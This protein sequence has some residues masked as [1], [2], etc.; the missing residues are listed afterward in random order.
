MKTQLQ[1]L[2]LVLGL[3]LGMAGMVKADTIPLYFVGL[4]TTKVIKWDS[5][6]Q[7]YYI[8]INSMLNPTLEFQ[9]TVYI[10]Y[11]DSQKTKVLY[12]S[13]FL[14]A[15]SYEHI[16]PYT[17]NGNN[18]KLSGVISEN[19]G[20][21]TWWAKVDIKPIPD[22]PNPGVLEIIVIRP[23][24]SKVFKL[25]Q[26]LGSLP[27]GIEGI[28]PKTINENVF[29]YDLTGQQV[30]AG[31][32][33]SFFGQHMQGLFIVKMGDGRASILLGDRR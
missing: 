6:N 22:Y 21:Y 9:D 29:V 27:T 32:I 26:A 10:N 23:S 18:S 1:K 16:Y 20:D 3:M 11:Y 4:D 33:N 13:V 14:N 7:E 2:G 30:F 5:V 12:S 17:Y 19:F 8:S 31:D 15:N 28:L 25:T 24:V